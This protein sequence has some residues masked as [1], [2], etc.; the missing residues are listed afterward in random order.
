M[1]SSELLSAI[2]VGSNINNLQ[3]SPYFTAYPGI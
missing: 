3:S 1:K 2:I